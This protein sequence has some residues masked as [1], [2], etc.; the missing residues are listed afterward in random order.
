MREI[1]NSTGDDERVEGHTS[2]R[3]PL[4][5]KRR[6]EEAAKSNR[7]S[8][9]AEIVARLAVSLGLSPTPYEP[10]HPIASETAMEALKLAEENAKRL[11]T[12]ENGLRAIC[13][14]DQFLDALNEPAQKLFAA[15]AASLPRDPD[16]SRN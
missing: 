16:E 14:A 11:A 5:L 12:I 9:S 8:L 4:G 6:L 2:V 10:A 3:I 1:V 15:L 7:K 13:S